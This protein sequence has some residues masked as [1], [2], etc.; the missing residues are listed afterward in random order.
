MNAARFGRRWRRL[1]FVAAVAVLL[2]GCAFPGPPERPEVRTFLLQGEPAASASATRS[3]PC[4]TLRIGSAGSAPGFHT[5]RMA[6]SSA[7]LQLDYFAWNSWTD[8]PANMIAALIETRLDRT[9]MLG[10]V[11]SGSSD[12]RT[13]FRLDLD[14]VELLQVFDD[15]S[16]EVRLRVKAR[17][18]DLSSHTLAASRTFV[19]TED[20]VAANPAAGAA[21][22]NRLA[23][24]LLGD[25]EEF[26]AGAL[27]QVACTK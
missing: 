8:T 2:A 11:V 1:S 26:I 7:P 10:A 22:A 12:V 6:Y 4:V 21:A 20:G 15:G 27:E 24:R 5:S 19:Y 13:D 23:G 25:V 9:G 16:S 14:G 18:I 17:I 3:W